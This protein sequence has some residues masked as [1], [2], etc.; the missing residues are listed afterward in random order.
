MRTAGLPQFR[1]LYGVL[2]DGLAKGEYTLKIQNSYDVS[3]F[4]GSKAFVL[5]TTN[6]LGG[7]NYFL[8]IAYIVVGVLCL[9]L[10]LI[11]FGVMLS[12]RGDTKKPVQTN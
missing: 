10:A 5:S 4:S 8:S 12:K 7:K 11:F 6:I 3:S 9:I 1:K 2:K